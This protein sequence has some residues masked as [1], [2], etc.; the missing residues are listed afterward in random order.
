MVNS[1]FRLIWHVRGA[2]NQCTCE[3]GDCVGFPEM[4]RSWRGHHT[5]Y[6]FLEACKFVPRHSCRSVARK[7]QRSSQLDQ[8]TKTTLT[9]HS[10]YQC[11]DTV[12]FK[13]KHEAQLAFCRERFLYAS[14][15]SVVLLTHV[16]MHA[17]FACVC[18]C[19]CVCSCV[20]GIGHSNKAIDQGVG[21]WHT[22]Q[23]GVSW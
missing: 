4:R 10:K 1:V 14:Y 16:P 9:V 17:E 8:P 23:L 15:I 18:E 21:E 3:L 6:L 12:S 22:Q 7:A 20:C 2:P 13:P 11:A 19:V 5:Q